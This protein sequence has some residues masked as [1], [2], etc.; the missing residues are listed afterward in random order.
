M[1]I[2]QAAPFANKM[3]IRTFHQLRELLP[4]LSDF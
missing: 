3:V 2:S 4:A 1:E